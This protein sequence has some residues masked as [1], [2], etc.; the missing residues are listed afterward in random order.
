MEI[1]GYS[2]PEEPYY[3]KDH[4]WARVEADGNG[5]VDMNSSTAIPLLLGSRF[6]EDIKSRWPGF[7]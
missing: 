1:E 5:R 2:I 3:T 7:F 4:L 6:A